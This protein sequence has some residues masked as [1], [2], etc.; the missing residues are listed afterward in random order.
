MQPTQQE[1]EQATKA[2]KE[3]LKLIDN[4]PLDGEIILTNEF[5]SRF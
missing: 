5:L 4:K 3:R 2:W 1:I